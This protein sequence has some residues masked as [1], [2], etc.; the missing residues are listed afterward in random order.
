MLKSALA[1]LTFVAAPAAAQPLTAA[2]IAKIDQAVTTTLAET[3]VPSAEIAV[4]R[5][6][7]IVLNKAYGKANE[8]LPA[9]TNLPT[10]SRRTRN[11]S[12]PW[13]CCCSRTRGS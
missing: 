7:Q 11:S 12:R 1:L 13:R 6:G 4:V 10:R 5:D 8:G 3:A 9:N 2:E